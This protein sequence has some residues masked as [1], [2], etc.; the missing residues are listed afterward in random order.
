MTAI[1][2][3]TAGYP[4]R[5]CGPRRVERSPPRRVAGGLRT[6]FRRSPLSAFWGC[7]A[8][9]IIV[10]AMAAPVFAPYEPLKSDFRAMSK[11]PNERHYFGTDQIGR[12]MSEPGHL[13]QPAP[14]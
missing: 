8:A 1:E 3:R 7:I 6:F 11:P 4:V 9:A 14:R 2:S 13:R 5:Q 12:D 10:M